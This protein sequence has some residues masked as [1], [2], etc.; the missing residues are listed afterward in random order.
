MSFSFI[1]ALGPMLR[2]KRDIRAKNA[3]E[4]LL[5]SGPSSISRP[6]SSKQVLWLFDPVIVYVALW[7]K[8]LSQA[9]SIG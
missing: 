6:E 3:E 7:A 1:A 8:H 5:D 2:Q 4:S 9:C